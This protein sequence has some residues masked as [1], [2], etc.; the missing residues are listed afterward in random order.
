MNPK[1][2]SLS[3]SN[4]MKTALICLILVLACHDLA[5]AQLWGP[6][7]LSI[8]ADRCPR[9]KPYCYMNSACCPPRLCGSVV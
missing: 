4:K 2:I 1:H 5:N 9:G 6:T 3:F 7:E 8:D